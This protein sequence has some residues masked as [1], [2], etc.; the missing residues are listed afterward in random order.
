MLKSSQTEQ[1]TENRL[2]PEFNPTFEYIEGT[3]IRE[4]YED[5][6]GLYRPYEATALIYDEEHQNKVWEM[7]NALIV[8]ELGDKVAPKTL[9]YIANSIQHRM[10][11]RDGA[12][13]SS[14]TF[15]LNQANETL[16]ES[17]KRALRGLGTIRDNDNARRFF[18]MPSV[19]Y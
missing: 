6:G 3:N 2:I 14:Y 9:K 19:E 15:R 11:A 10:Y 12:N 5:R 17:C 18:G 7:L 13:S 1:E 4:P 8:K 16:D